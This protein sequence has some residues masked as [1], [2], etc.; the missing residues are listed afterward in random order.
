MKKRLAVILALAALLVA[1][2]VPA[3]ASAHPLGNFTVNHFAAVDLAGN[4]VYVRY[5]LDLAEIP[6]FQMGADVTQLSSRANSSCASTAYACRSSRCR[7]ALRSDR[8]QGG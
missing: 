1:L 6:T 3:G 7:T 8:A 2:V 5:A 4:T